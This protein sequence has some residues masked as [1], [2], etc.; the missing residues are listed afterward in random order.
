MPDLS[1][2]NLAINKTFNTIRFHVFF[3]ISGFVV[4]TTKNNQIC[5]ESQSK[6]GLKLITVSHSTVTNIFADQ[7]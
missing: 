1:D 2:S 5:I 7:L 6:L 4:R 3:S